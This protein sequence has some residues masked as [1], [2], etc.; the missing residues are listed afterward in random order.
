MVGKLLLTPLAQILQ[1]VRKQLGDS[2][3]GTGG[4]RNPNDQLLVK[5][6]FAFPV[7]L[8]IFCYYRSFL[9]VSD[10]LQAVIYDVDWKN[11]LYNLICFRLADKQGFHHHIFSKFL[12]WLCKANLLPIQI[13]RH[14]CIFWCWS[15]FIFFCQFES[16]GCIS[17]GKVIRKFIYI[18]YIL[19]IKEFLHY[20]EK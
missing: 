4:G 1:N 6:L 15:C 8:L 10:S 7:F 19:S 9:Q 2:L 13:W 11:C 17:E 12:M 20:L 14:S 3:P 5:F 16:T 18:C